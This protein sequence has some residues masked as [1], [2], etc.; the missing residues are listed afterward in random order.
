MNARRASPLPAR[1]L[2]ER[3]ADIHDFASFTRPATDPRPAGRPISTPSRFASID[4]DALRNAGCI[5]PGEPAGMIAEEFR[6]V[7]RHLLQPGGAARDRLILVTSAQPGEG[8]TFCAV[9]LALSMA[10]ERD[11][12]VLLVD[13]DF[14]RPG[15]LARLGVPE[16]AGLMDAVTDPAV[17]VERCIVRT[18]VRG[19]SVMPAGRVIHDGNEYLA[20]ARAASLLAGLVERHP[21]RVVILDSPAVLAASIAADLARHAG[22]ALLVVRAD[23]TVEAD[24]AEA[25]GLIGACPHIRLLLNDAAFNARR[26]RFGPHYGAPQRPPFVPG[27]HG[28][29]Q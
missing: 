9:N 10:S 20:S 2:L 27:E 19:L 5:I 13:A 14:T 18:D 1:S 7:K 25:I 11:I 15:V 26:R 21:S 4:L 16:G 24:I 17:D 12:E 22:Q 23:R 6:L 29:V 28:L 3:A 8:K